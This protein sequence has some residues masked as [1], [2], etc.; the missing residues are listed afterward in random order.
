L[1]I[2]LQELKDKLEEVSVD[3][4]TLKAEL[5]TSPTGGEP[6]EKVSFEYK[7]LE[8]QNARLQETLLK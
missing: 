8:Q 2:E 7:Q 1:G 6:R 5:D 4:E 3:Y